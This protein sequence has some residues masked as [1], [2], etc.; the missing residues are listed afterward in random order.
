MGVRLT[1]AD[2][3]RLQRGAC[4]PR[5]PAALVAPASALRLEVVVPVRVVSE[6]NVRCHWAARHRR[7]KAQAG[8]VFAALVA[9]S[10]VASGPD[11]LRGRVLRI[12]LTRLGGRGLDSDNLAG[13]FKGCRD[14][15][16]QFLGRDDGDPQLTWDY[17]Q[18]P[19]KLAGVRIVLET[20]GGG[21]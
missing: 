4:P 19:G 6:A 10:G 14:V 3:K 15:V 17:S 13:A 20:K 16:A 7:F 12:L 8:A 1:E 18:E 11:L 21:S 5:K 2:L 9:A